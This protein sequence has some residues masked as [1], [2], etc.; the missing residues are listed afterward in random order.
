MKK[1]AALAGGAVLAVVMTACSGTSSQPAP[2][3]TASAAAVVNPDSAAWSGVVADV[4][5]YK[6]A[7][8]TPAQITGQEYEAPEDKA[9]IAKMVTWALTQCGGQ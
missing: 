2:T 4:C 7:G 1:I 6:T 8:L 5:R 9:V 3:G